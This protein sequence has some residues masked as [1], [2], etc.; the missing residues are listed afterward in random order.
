MANSPPREQLAIAATQIID[1]KLFTALCEPIRV[2][3]L[4]RLIQLGRSDI[5]EICTGFKQDRSVISRHL[6]VLKDAGILVSAKE[7]R[8]TFYEVDGPGVLKRLEDIVD[9]VRLVEPFCRPENRD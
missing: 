5:G 8:H 4:A 1:T 2:Q 3:I 6:V 7:G 9:Q